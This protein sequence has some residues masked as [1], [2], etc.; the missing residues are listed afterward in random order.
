MEERNPEMRAHPD[1]VATVDATATAH[2][3]GILFSLCLAALMINIDVT[4]VNVTLPALVR[5]L[6]ATTTDLQWV[7]DAYSLVFAA[8]I[9]AA[10]SLSDR[11]GRKGIL[12]VGL[13]VFAAGS[14]AGSLATTP[15][16]LI[17]ARAVMGIGAAGIF[18]ST[19]SLIANVF[20]ERGERAKAI[21]LWGATT[22]V[23]I[24]TGP[25]IGG[26]LL[27]H[28]WWGSVFLFIVP[29]AAVVA[30]FI[31]ATVP[32]SKDP[33]AAPLDRRG[34]RLSTAGMALLIFG[35]IQAP[36]WGWGS[37]T[38]LAVLVAGIV[39][40]SVFVAVERR[41]A[42]PMLDVALFK[43][44]RFTAASGS[45]TFGFFTLTGFTFLITQ[46]FQFV[47]D[48]S[49]LDTGVRLLPVALSVGAA[50]I[51]GTKL[52]VRIG[53][54]AVVAGGLLLFGIT[55]LWIAGVASQTTPYGVIA[56]QMVLG[57][58][59]LGL[60][61]A[62][63]TEAIM[64]A[65][66]AEKAGV[67]SAVNDAT[68]LF[69]ATLGVA[70]IGSIAASLYANRLGATLPADVPSNIASVADGS[71]GGA[72]TAARQMVATGLTEPGRALSAAAID[73]FLHSLAGALRVAAGVAFAGSVIAA[74]FLPSR[75]QA[76]T[77]PQPDA[78]PD[79]AIDEVPV[80]QRAVESDAGSTPVATAGAKQP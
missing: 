76:H 43:D 32:T 3:G 2:K 75:P 64:G 69:G 8:L 4:I 41:T 18:P 70:V 66:P 59:G 31:A 72:L 23:G 15:G 10:G 30:G 1:D 55:L 37:A 16:E 62:P 25:I 19:L 29:V 13:G 54:K 80:P 56:L 17:A 67:G 24:A 44:M 20:T 22:G 63:A 57:G 79:P 12:L 52:A 61:T 21:G 50:A 77:E 58:S 36:A 9:L 14:L 71:V 68:R 39:V 28:F 60:I 46:Y 49:P 78:G 45:I 35:I 48:Y 74:I 34:L 47:K 65:V 27:E 5:E 7:V 53:N 73:A 26:W 42:R 38:T 33:D 11:V 6:G 51:V 40:L